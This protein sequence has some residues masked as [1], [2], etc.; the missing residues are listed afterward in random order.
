[1]LNE[2]SAKS[3][4]NCQILLSTQERLLL[5]LLWLLLLYAAPV[6]QKLLQKDAEQID[7]RSSSRKASAGIAAT[8]M[9]MHG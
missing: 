4:G 2:S 6:L 7:I 1:M 5:T 3:N 9:L 8:S